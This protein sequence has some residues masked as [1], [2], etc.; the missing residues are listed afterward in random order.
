MFCGSVFNSDISRW[1]VNN[2]KYMSNIFYNCP[3]E[4]EYKPARF[5]NR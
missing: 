2:V 3:I 5:Q 4:E 1:D